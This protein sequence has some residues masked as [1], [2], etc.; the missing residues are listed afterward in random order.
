MNYKHLGN[1]I[2]EERQKLNLTQEKLAESIGISD[3]YMG[4][5]ERGE[6]S[7]TLDTLTRLANRLGATID[8]L[9]QDSVTVNNDKY[10]D[11]LAQ[12]MNG[13]TLK[14]KQ[15]ALDVIKIVFS[16]LDDNK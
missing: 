7:L 1:R 9:L 6:R 15:M 16:H 10:L 8:F 3:S 14:Q 13:R 11:Q 5:I 2:R 12:L 4:Q